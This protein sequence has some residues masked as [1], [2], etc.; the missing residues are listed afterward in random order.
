MNECYLR[1]D[2]VSLDYGGSSARRMR[3]LSPK[4]NTSEPTSS[5][6]NGVTLSITAG[7]SVAL[8]GLNGA[9]KTTLL[10]TLAGIYPPTSGSIEI[11]GATQALIDSGYGLDPEMSGRVNAIFR[12]RLMGK[13]KTEALSSAE[14]VKSFSELEEY[15]DSPVRTYSSGMT[16]RLLFAINTVDIPEILILDEGIGA[17]DARFQEKA[18]LRLTELLDSA[19]IL[20]LA[21]HSTEMVRRLCSRAILLDHG[22]IVEDGPIDDVINTYQDR[23]R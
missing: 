2:N 6:L 9:G 15:F 1:L 10:R 18:Q 16:A 8:L 23:C 3:L 14:R 17:G 11:R 21:S 5:A 7:E 20:V 4:F 19:N 12:A 22:K 13:S